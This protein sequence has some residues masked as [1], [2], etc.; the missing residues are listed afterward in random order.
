MVG[1]KLAR[2]IKQGK[3]SDGELSDMMY[4]VVISTSPLKLQIDNRLVVGS[5]HLIL[6]Q[7][8]RPLSVSI[9]IDGKTGTGQVFRSLQVGDRVR[10]LR[11]SKGQKFYV[12]E[13]G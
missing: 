1:E 7:M 5:Q 3:P 12:L 6:S 2:A 13:R 8:V 9:T 10:V 4:G 11:V